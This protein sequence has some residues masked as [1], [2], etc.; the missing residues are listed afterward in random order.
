MN[1]K[2][3][4]KLPIDQYSEAPVSGMSGGV[5]TENKFNTENK[6]FLA[7]TPVLLS[8]LLN[9]AGN[10]YL[11]ENQSHSSE[12]QSQSSENQSKKEL[13]IPEIPTWYIVV[14]NAAAIACIYHGYKRNES[15]AW[16]LM[17]GLGGAMLPL[18]LPVV[19]IAQGFAEP[20]KK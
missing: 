9:F 13:K 17:W 19:A 3:T 15:V 6:S 5:F 7:S 10:H 1:K 4:Y 11:G 20:K 12:N 2:F 8:P 18:V 14:S 16:A